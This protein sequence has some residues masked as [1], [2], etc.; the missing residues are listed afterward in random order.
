[1]FWP[2]SARGLVASR[3]RRLQSQG[4]L[5]SPRVK[6]G[7]L[8]AVSGVGVRMEW[9]L[10][11]RPYWAAGLPVPGGQWLRGELRSPGPV[12][13]E[14]WE[15]PSGPQAASRALAELCWISEPQASSPQIRGK[16]ALGQASRGCTGEVEEGGW[17]GVG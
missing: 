5:V 2:K 10:R 1:M 17:V 16:W 6:E 7:V 9:C 14:L 11:V 3:G 13:S 12:H 4:S 15:A 8:G